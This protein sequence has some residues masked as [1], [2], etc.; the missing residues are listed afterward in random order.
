MN[1]LKT[2]LTINSCLMV[3]GTTVR[4]AQTRSHKRR[5]LQ[6]E[7]YIPNECTVS[8]F[9]QA[10]GGQAALAALLGV[11]NNL[12]DIEAE[13]YS[14]CESALAPAIDFSDTLGKGPQFLKNFLDGGTTWNDNYADME[15]GGPY[16]LATDAAII[17][18]LSGD[19]TSIVFGTPDGGT[20]EHYDR[21]F[22]NFYAGEQEC[23][24]GV[25]ECCYT[26]S[27]KSAH[28][29]MSLD[30]NAEMCALDLTPAAKSNH[31]KNLSFTMY[32]TQPGDDTYCSGFAY[33]KD[34]FGDKVKYNTFFHMAM[35][36]NLY[37]NGFV[38]NIP[39]APLCGCV[40]QMP[41]VDNAA[42]VTAI[43]G[44]KMD[45]DGNV[46]L[47]IKW[48]D[49]GTDLASHYETLEGRTELEKYFVKEKIVGEGNCA[50]ASTSFMNDR[51][52]IPIDYTRGANLALQGTAT[53]S[54]T[55]HNGAPQ[56]AIDGNTSGQW[57]DA[58]VTHTN[59]EAQPWWKVEL[60]SP[61]SINEVVVWNRMDCCSQRLSNSNIEILDGDGNVIETQVLGISSNLNKFEFDFG[62]VVGSAVRVQLQGSE[63][64]SLAEVEVFGNPN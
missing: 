49:C 63:H 64:L 34:S 2:I 21:Y 37:Q 20:S 28:G 51:M 59:Y 44:Y 12:G 35:T 43:E 17:P 39:G 45:A 19:S 58:T 25:I 47:D 26:S 53:Q 7:Y 32:D 5:N 41:I 8:N 33:E 24:L 30:D 48:D 61:S 42:C 54:S 57:A 6:S 3:S 46:S 62:G 38:K 60:S 40:E 18:T 23:Q 52:Y 16:E 31:I 4:G 9:E 36:T 13:L 56:R 11:S 10:V 50:A 22:S 55:A 15:G 1:A 29:R 27:R 14:R